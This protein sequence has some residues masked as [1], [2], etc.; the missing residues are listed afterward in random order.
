[1]DLQSGL[2]VFGFGLLMIVI[3]SVVGWYCFKHELKNE[4]A[5]MPMATLANHASDCKKGDGYSS[6]VIDGI[7]LWLIAL[8]VLFMMLDIFTFTVI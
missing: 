3:A 4:V 6:S 5:L 2:I 7:L 1:M 8:V